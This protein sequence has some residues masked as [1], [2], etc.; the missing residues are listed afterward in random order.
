MFAQIIVS[1]IGKQF[2]PFLK[3][4]TT[5]ERI[6]AAENELSSKKSTILNME[7][8]DKSRNFP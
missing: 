5:Q 3:S 8:I 2:L 7:K 6:Y 1:L 4:E